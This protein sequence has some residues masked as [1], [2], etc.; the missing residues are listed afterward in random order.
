[1]TLMFNLCEFDQIS[2]R[3]QHLN[4]NGYAAFILLL[5]AVAKYLAQFRFRGVVIVVH[6]ISARCCEMSCIFSARC[7]EISYSVSVVFYCLCG[8]VP[9]CRYESFMPFGGGAEE[10]Q[11]ETE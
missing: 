8:D 7:C 1:M 4:Q 10:H 3:G 2:L 9:H 6:I 11:H 5:P